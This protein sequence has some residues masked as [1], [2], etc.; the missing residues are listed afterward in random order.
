MTYVVLIPLS[1]LIPF[2][3]VSAVIEVLGDYLITIIL[4]LLAALVVVFVIMCGNVLS[5]GEFVLTAAVI[6]IGAPIVGCMLRSHF[7]QRALEEQQ[8]E[9]ARKEQKKAEYWMLRQLADEV[10]YTIEYFE[11]IHPS[12]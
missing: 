11:A 2:L 12:R 9:R 3:I 1:M 6:L 4:W 7:E 5:F 8:R 10:D